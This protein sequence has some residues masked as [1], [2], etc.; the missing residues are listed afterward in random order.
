MSVVII[1]AVLAIVGIAFTQ[2]DGAYHIEREVELAVALVVEVVVYASHEVALSEVF[3]VCHLVVESLVV[4]APELQVL[5]LH[6]DD[7]SLLLA[8]DAVGQ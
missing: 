8:V 6:K 4:A 5:K 2:G 7:E 1:V 3:L